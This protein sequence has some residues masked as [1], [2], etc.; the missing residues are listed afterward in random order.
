MFGPKLR[1]VRRARG[2]SQG[3][4]ADKAEINRSY[5]SMIENGHSSPTMDVVSRLAAG[6]GVNTWR[7]LADMDAEHFTYDL[8]DEFEMYGAL[9][10]LLSDKSQMMLIQPGVDEVEMLKGIRF[11]GGYVPDKQFYLDAILAYRRSETSR[12]KKEE[13]AAAENTDSSEI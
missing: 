4:L 2:M 12:K 9:N 6:L 13:A 3:D 7:L 8:D 10:E 5:L 11:S 1:K